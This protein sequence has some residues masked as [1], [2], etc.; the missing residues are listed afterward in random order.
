MVQGN[1][2]EVSEDTLTL[3]QTLTEPHICL[4]K[5]DMGGNVR[6]T[7][8]ISLLTIT[9]THAF[10][11]KTADRLEVWL[12]VQYV[13]EVWVLSKHCTERQNQKE[14]EEEEKVPTS[15]QLFL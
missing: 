7:T 13:H 14:K 12:S 10:C 9:N 5:R 2:K 3:S 8:S 1:E 6:E 15:S 11:I 4:L